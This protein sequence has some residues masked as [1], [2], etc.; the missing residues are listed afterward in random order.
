MWW[1][2]NSSIWRES[3]KKNYDFFKCFI[4][5]SH[6]NFSSHF[7]CV[8]SFFIVICLSMSDSVGLWLLYLDHSNICMI[9]CTARYY[10]V[11]IWRCDHNVRIMN[12]VL[13]RLLVFLDVVCGSDSSFQNVNYI[14]S[15]LDVVPIDVDVKMLDCILLPF[16]NWTSSFF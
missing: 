10:L 1:Q 2:Y 16:Y 8:L 6:N 11:L 4:L 5:D 12:P 15:T 3:Y 7:L 9:I 13:V 14:S